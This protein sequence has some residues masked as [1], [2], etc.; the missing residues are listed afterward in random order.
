MLYVNGDFKLFHGHFY[1]YVGVTTQA[2]NK[3]DL[4]PVEVIYIFINFE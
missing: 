3:N 4:Y 1:L 2:G